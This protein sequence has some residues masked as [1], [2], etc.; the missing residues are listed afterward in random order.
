[1]AVDGTL[2][3]WPIG[4]HRLCTCL[5]PIHM[6]ACSNTWRECR[7]KHIRRQVG[8]WCWSY[9][10]A[11]ARNYTV[12]DFGTSTSSGQKTLET[13][14]ICT[15]VIFANV[16]ALNVFGRHLH[17]NSVFDFIDLLNWPLVVVGVVPHLYETNGVVATR[18][19]GVTNRS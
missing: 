10:L 9:I 11:G 17:S 8:V 15:C 6:T 3:A 13:Y 1:M 7:C 5:E 12:R 14:E 18:G 19:L 4:G 16:D 2:V